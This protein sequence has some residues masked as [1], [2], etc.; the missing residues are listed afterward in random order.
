MLWNAVTTRSGRARMA[1]QGQQFINS[2]IRFLQSILQP[3]V[4]IQ[5]I[6][7][8]CGQK[9][10]DGC[11]SLARSFRSSV[12]PIFLANGYGTNSVLDAVIVDGQVSSRG[13]ACQGFPAFQVVVHSPG[14]SRAVWHDSAL[15]DE[16]LTKTI[17]DGLRL[18]LTNPPPYFVSV[19]RSHLFLDKG[20]WHAV[21]LH[22]GASAWKGQVQSLL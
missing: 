3:G 16:P 9:T 21:I 13:V 12:Q 14:Y 11:C 8:G 20:I 15:V 4:E 18:L 5:S 6:E 10:L 22:R 2:T 17:K 1:A 19:R 7:F